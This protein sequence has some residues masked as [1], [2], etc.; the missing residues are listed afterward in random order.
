MSRRIFGRAKLLE[1]WRPGP[2]RVL[3]A[4]L[5]ASLLPVPALAYLDAWAIAGLLG[6][7]V[8]STGAFLLTIATWPRQAARWLCGEPD[9]IFRIETGTAGLV[10][11]VFGAVLIVRGLQAMGMFS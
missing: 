4:V 6:L 5:L 11:A 3:L 1:A 8:A 7:V 10:Y 2:R 9:R